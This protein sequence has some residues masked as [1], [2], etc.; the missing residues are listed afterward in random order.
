MP[1]IKVL[2]NNKSGSPESIHNAIESG[3]NEG[4]NSIKETQQTTNPAVVNNGNTKDQ[5]ANPLQQIILIIEHKIRN[6]EKRKN[7]LESYKTIEKSGKKL[8]SDQKVAVSKYDECLASLELTREL[9]KQFQSIAAVA[10]REAKKEA[11]RSAFVRAQQ[12]NAK[13]REVLVI[14]DVL[15]RICTETVRNDFVNGENGACKVSD[16]DLLVLE[17]IYEVVQPKRP[18]NTAEPTFVTTIKQAADHLSAIVDGRNKSFNE[19][20]YGSIKN[21][22]DEIQNCGYFEKDLIVVEEQLEADKDGKT[23]PADTNEPVDEIKPNDICANVDAENLKPSII[24][25]TDITSTNSNEVNRSYGFTEAPAAEAVPT[26]SFP[27]QQSSLRNNSA[28]FSN[29]TDTCSILAALIPPSNSTNSANCGN[30][31]TNAINIQHA[32]PVIP[33]GP[34]A[35]S[36]LQSVPGQQLSATTVQAVEHA[37]FKQHY[38]QQQMRPIHE[39]IG[40]A[41]FY[42]LQESE[43]DKPDIVATPG[44]YENT[45]VI[46]NDLATSKPVVPKQ[47]Q[48]PSQMNLNHLNSSTNMQPNNQSTIKP[49]HPANSSTQHQLPSETLQS[50]TFSN[51]PFITAGGSTFNHMHPQSGQHTSVKQQTTVKPLIVSKTNELNHIPGFTSCNTTVVSTQTVLPNAQNMNHVQAQPQ[52]QQQQILQNHA[53]VQRQPEQNVKMNQTAGNAN[54]TSSILSSSF[55]SSIQQ[56]PS[57]MQGMHDSTNTVGTNIVQKM[58]TLVVDTPTEKLKSAMKLSENL[59]INQPTKTMQQT[60]QRDEWNGS[61]DFTATLAKPDEQWTSSPVLIN[62]SGENCTLDNSQFVLS[63]QSHHQKPQSNSSSSVGTGVPNRLEHNGTTTTNF[64][65]NSNSIHD[66]KANHSQPRFTADNEMNNTT[67]TFFKNNERYYQQNNSNSFGSNKTN[68]SYH[69]RSSMFKSRPES[70]GNGTARSSGFGPMGAG[71]NNQ[72][73]GTNNNNDGIVDYRS[74]RPVN[75]TRNTGP[76]TNARS[77]RNHS[78]NGNYGGPR[79]SSGSNSRGQSTLNA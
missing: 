58:S 68:S 61:T 62:S 8:T 13:I 73:A 60:K 77:Q 7:K 75:S 4:F 40:T 46:P 31:Q 69:Q 16:D 72:T 26:P 56:F 44:R 23:T 59:V 10:N 74:N 20:T 43:I 11:K 57:L 67:S 45:S 19:S 50:S 64:V 30:A 17:K 48:Q 51:Q 41:N 53:Q 49:N 34:V 63:R 29:S 54:Q 9:C 21:V 2:E 52:H 25:D 28:P 37:Y 65:S 66:T 35:V 47:Q 33:S 42:F 6:L 3:G 76:P 27:I 55:N 12:E 38:I 71:V 1:S 78:G 70:N 32:A 14:Q 5:P 79:G 36:P 22:I 39:V 24:A 15:K 18:E